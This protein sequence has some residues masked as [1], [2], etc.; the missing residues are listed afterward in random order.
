MRKNGARGSHILYQGCDALGAF[1]VIS[2]R[3]ER[4]PVPF[5]GLVIR[6]LRDGEGIPSMLCL[7][8]GL[9]PAALLPPEWPPQASHNS[10]IRMQDRF[11]HG[12]ISNVGR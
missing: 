12:C 7:V 11:V 2:W 5:R 6:A 8:S 4:A 10:C 9:I 1:F 3:P